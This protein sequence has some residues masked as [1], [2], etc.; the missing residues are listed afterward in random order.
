LGEKKKR[1][2]NF[3]KPPLLKKKAT[4][5]NPNRAS[6]TH[7]K[8]K[9]DKKTGSKKLLVGKAQKTGIKDAQKN[10]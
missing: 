10:R 2:E 8:Q 4:A 1:G 5:R 3:K 9:L 6:R 7:P